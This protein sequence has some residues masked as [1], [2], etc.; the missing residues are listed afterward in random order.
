[1][2]LRSWLLPLAVLPLLAACVNDSASYQDARKERSI[3]LIRQ[4]RWLW[5]KTVDAAV[6][7]ARL[8]DC[9]RR[10]D[11]GKISPRATIEL[12]QPGPGTYVLRQGQRLI[13]T[14]TQTCEGWRQL[15]EE[16][17]GGLG[18]QLGAFAPDDGK[19]RFQASGGEPAGQ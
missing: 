12:W 2:R 14:E 13:L 11:L 16:P 9:Q 8:P 6:V 18:L 3:T 7:V 4:Q 10:H 1:M 17:P 15:E 5:D 19:L